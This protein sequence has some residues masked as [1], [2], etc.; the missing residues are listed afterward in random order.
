MEKIQV[1]KEKL[2]ERCEMG[3]DQ[4][5]CKSVLKPRSSFQK[6]M[7]ASIL[8]VLLSTAA[9]YHSQVM[10]A[11][12]KAIQY[13]PGIGVVEEEEQSGN[14]YVLDETKEVQ[15]EGGTVTVTNIVVDGEQTYVV[16]NGDGSPKY[17][18]ITIINESGK[19]Y[20]VKSSHSSWS[21]KQWT[22]WFWKDEAL[23]LS[24]N[25]QVVIGETRISV[26]MVEAKS[27]ESFKEMGITDKTNDLA[28]TAIPSR[29]SEKGRIAFVSQHSEKFKIA[30]YGFNSVHEE[31]ELSITDPDQ[32]QYEINRYKGISQPTNEFY[33]QLA[34]EDVS[35]YNLRIPEVNVQYKDEKKITLPLPDDE[36]EM[37]KTFK[38]AGYPVDITK[39]ERTDEDELRIYVDVHYDK[40]DARSL[41]NFRIKH[42]SHMAKVDLQTRAIQYLQYKVDW[43][44]KNVNL[45]F[46]EP[47]VLLR[48]PWKYE[49][50]SEKFMK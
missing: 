33:F 37:N 46:S 21:S 24:G 36:I 42:T 49:I 1:P 7:V 38:L 26:K 19:E 5:V 3:I 2:R 47:Q 34:A 20:I 30:N 44:K 31:K 9:M 35:H 16:L 23:S 14:S 41:H 8:I 11:V 39:L 32:N 25:V 28:I 13:I 18:E 45:T 17:Q 15:V 43:N 40:Q 4:A 10:A 22:T 6:W 12:Q 50:P 27:Y 29:D 48:G